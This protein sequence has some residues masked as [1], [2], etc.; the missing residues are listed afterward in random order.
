MWFGVRGRR[1]MSIARITPGGH[2]TLFSA[3]L[4]A[5]AP[6]R[7]LAGGPDG[8]VWFTEDDTDRVG[9]ITPPGEIT[10]FHAGI[11]SG[12]EPSG[13]VA[14]PDGN[15]WFT[16]FEGGRLGRITPAG[17][18]TEF[19]AGLPPGELLSA[20]TS[21]PDASLWFPTLEGVARLT[22]T[23]G[24]PVSVLTRRAR[25]SSRGATA[26]QLACG[27]GTETCAGRL[28]LTIRATKRAGDGRLYIKVT[29]VASARFGLSPG[30]HTTVKLTLNS[31]GRRQLARAR[32]R[33]LTTR[34]RAGSSA[35][36]EP[37]TLILTGARRGR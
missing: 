35:G 4:H 5:N 29:L 23:P 17:K 1:A 2:V 24:T 13:I 21:G 28:D 37:G 25:V 32:G 14:G 30:R 7:A 16:E 9:R 20:I 31:I 26:V 8:N 10:E 22:P 15:L 19:S 27:A 12:S 18:V 34:F 36:D 6:P 11:S 3:G 33:R